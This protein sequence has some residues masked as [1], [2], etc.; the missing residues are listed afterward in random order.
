[1]GLRMKK[2][3]LDYRYFR[4]GESAPPESIPARYAYA[5]YK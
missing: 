1:M 2:Y 5:P 4:K 3:S